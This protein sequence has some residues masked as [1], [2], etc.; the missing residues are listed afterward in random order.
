MVCPCLGAPQRNEGLKQ[1]DYRNFLRLFNKQNPININYITHILSY[2]LIISKKN[3]MTNPFSVFYN[4]Y[5]LTLWIYKEHVVLGNVCVQN[6]RISGH[7][8]SGNLSTSLK[9]S[10]FINPFLHIRPFKLFHTQFLL[11]I[12]KLIENSRSRWTQ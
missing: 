8:L 5:H 1:E 3:Y 4:I 10:I 7:F 2:I 11:C 6:K 12:S 9:C